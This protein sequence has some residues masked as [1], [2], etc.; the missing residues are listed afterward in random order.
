MFKLNVRS[1]GKKGIHQK[2]KSR[3][4]SAGN[5]DG[6]LGEI[7][8]NRDGIKLYAVRNELHKSNIPSKNMTVKNILERNKND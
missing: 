7:T 5:G 3:D 4:K 8:M 2:L 6:D 1:E